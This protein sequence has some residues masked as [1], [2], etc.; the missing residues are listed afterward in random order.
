MATQKVRFQLRSDTAAEWATL[1]PILANGEPGFEKD[2]GLM[3]IGDGVTPFT[4]LVA[5]ARANAV[6][7]LTRQIATDAAAGTAGGGDLSANRTIRL[8]GKA[9]QLHQIGGTDVFY[10]IDGS[11]N[12]VAVPKDAYALHEPGTFLMTAMPTSEVPYR[13]LRCTGAAVSRTVYAA[14]FAKIGTAWGAGDG[15]TTFNI[16][17]ARGRF[18]RGF[19]DG[20]GRDPGRV[21]GTYQLDALQNLTGSL[22]S[23]GGRGGFANSGNTGVFGGQGTTAA[24]HSDGTNLTG[25]RDIAF[26]ASLVARTAAETR[27]VNFTTN[28]FIRY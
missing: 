24:G 2:T 13:T 23:G 3:R 22:T 10:T 15:A 1:N 4:S 28:I 20:A 21:F 16:P 8:T 26:D 11:G 25:Y 7:P 14:L 17:D 6:P 12:V 9:L 5:Y 18:P 19:D 27:P